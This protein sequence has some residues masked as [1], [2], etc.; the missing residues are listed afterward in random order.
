MAAGTAAIRAAA[1]VAV[2]MAPQSSD[3]LKRPFP[4]QLHGAEA[5]SKKICLSSCLS[6]R[7]LVISFL[8]ASLRPASHNEAEIFNWLKES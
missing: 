1:A 5:Q 6:T 3:R 8:A 4:L 7:R 2:A